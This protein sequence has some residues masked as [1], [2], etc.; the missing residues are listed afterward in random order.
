MAA[1]LF[2]G[3]LDNPAPV[4][5]DGQARPVTPRRS[6]TLRAHRKF[7]ST[8]G[9]CDGGQPKKISAATAKE[10]TRFGA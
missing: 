1:V 2:V 7:E 6:T 3:A 4:S 10:S 8:A 9:T 5:T